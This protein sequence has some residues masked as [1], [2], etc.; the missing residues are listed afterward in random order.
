V[1]RTDLLAGAAAA[2]R[3]AEALLLGAVLGCVAVTALPKAR[4]TLGFCSLPLSAERGARACFAADLVSTPVRCCVVGVPL[5]ALPL[6]C[7]VVYCG[8]LLFSLSAAVDGL[9]GVDLVLVLLGP[10]AGRCSEGRLLLVEEGLKAGRCH[11]VRVGPFASICK[12]S[13]VLKIAQN[14]L[15]CHQQPAE[16]ATA[17][18]PA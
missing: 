3:G 17:A 12:Q 2:P 13:G 8:V 7:R 1:Q 15:L 6:D 10:V 9:L 5:P 16:C 4:V 11:F 18:T 14:T